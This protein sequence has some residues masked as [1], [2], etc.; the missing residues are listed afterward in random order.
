MPREDGEGYMMKHLCCCAV[1]LAGEGFN[2]VHRNEFSPVTWPEIMVLQT[3]H[4]EDAVFDIRPFALTPRENNNREKERLIL[5]YGRDAVEAVF[6][7][8][9]FHMEFFVPGW[10]IDPTKARRKPPNDRP[11]PL[12]IQKPTDDAAMDASI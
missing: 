9:A 4:G 12:K 8:K 1:D 5:I 6:A 11:K 2:I 7:G 3:I 10:P